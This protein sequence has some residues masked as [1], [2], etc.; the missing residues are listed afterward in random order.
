MVLFALVEN[1]CTDHDDDED[2]DDDCYYYYFCK[3]RTEPHPSLLDQFSL[4]WT[5]VLRT[6]QGW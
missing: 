3:F 1:P 6:K 4:F 5:C 2:D